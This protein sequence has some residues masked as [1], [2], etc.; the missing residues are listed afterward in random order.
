MVVPVLPLGAGE[1]HLVAPV[2]RHPVSTPRPLP[3]ILPPRRGYRLRAPDFRP[4]HVSHQT[5]LRAQPT[6][7]LRLRTPP[8]HL[9][10]VPQVA[11][12]HLQLIRRPHPTSR[13][14]RQ[15]FTHQHPRQRAKAQAQLL[16]RTVRHLPHSAH[17]RQCT[18]RPVHS[19]VAAAA[20][21][22][23]S[24]QTRQRRL[25]TARRRQPI[26]PPV[27]PGTHRTLPPRHSFQAR[28]GRH[29]IPLRRPNGHRLRRRLTL[30]RKTQ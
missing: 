2:P 16:L 10:L 6:L 13:H 9:R 21:Q 7:L 1:A 19:L 22:S 12:Q 4:L 11:L 30:L 26:A 20:A 15:T 3:P 28:R 8:A 29:H 23:V 17:R 27:P 18:A 24:H 25:H 14:P 5:V